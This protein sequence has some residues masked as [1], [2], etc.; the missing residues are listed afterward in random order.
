MIA[1]KNS[2][3]LC[4]DNLS[5]MPVWLSDAICRLSTGGGFGTRTLYSNEGETIFNSMRPVILN[6]ISDVASRHDLIDRGV[7]INL[8]MI[9]EDARKPEKG[10]LESF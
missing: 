5:G 8:E 9:P 7:M 3:V 6:G 2:W 4:F 10:N 1:G